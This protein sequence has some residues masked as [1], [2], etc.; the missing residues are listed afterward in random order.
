MS[1]CKYASVC[2]YANGLGCHTTTT[3]LFSS[4][5]KNE[6]HQR[7]KRASGRS[8][9]P[10]GDDLVG[11]RPDRDAK[12]TC[13]AKVSKLDVPL[14]VNQQVLRLEVAVQDSVRVAKLDSLEQLEHVAL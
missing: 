2:T 8:F 1:M 3:T 4:E 11:V 9:V 5:Q 7:E 12:G 13:Q 10:E 14:G 6:N